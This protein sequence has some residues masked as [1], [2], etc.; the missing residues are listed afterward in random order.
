VAAVLPLTRRLEFPGKRRLRRVVRLP[1]S[2][3][4]DVELLGA[5]FRLDLSESLHRDY[6][7]GLCDRLELRLLKRV[8]ARGGDFVD[9]GAHVGMYAVCTARKIDGRVLAL[10]PNPAAFAQ[11]EHNVSLNGCRNVITEPLAASDH[12]GYATLRVPRH[13][14]SSW[15]SLAEGRVQDVDAVEVETTTL[16]DEVAR[17]GIRPAAVKIDVEGCEPAVLRGACDVL[18]RRP[19]L[20]IELVEENARAVIRALRRIGYAVAR[21]G[22]RRLEPWPDAPGASNA[23]FLQPSHLSLLSR[24]ERGTFAGG[25]EHVVGE[26]RPAR[27]QSIERAG[28]D[29]WGAGQRRDRAE[30]LAGDANDLEAV[31]LD[32]LA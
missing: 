20:F 27:R 31:L 13:G 21:A 24:R 1:E 17:H 19:A 16:D 22:T 3:L 30:A 8:L 26:R 23:V 29:A 5:R 6:Y 4:R 32:E 18:E 28:H 15:S 9:V 12:P 2:G 14:D 11:L 10:E 25:E 7:F